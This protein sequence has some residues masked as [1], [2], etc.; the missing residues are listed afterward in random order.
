MT[1]WRSSRPKAPADQIDI[2]VDDDNSVP[3]PP[4]DLPPSEEGV[5]SSGKNDS[6]GHTL[7]DDDDNV[8]EGSIEHPYGAGPPRRKFCTGGRLFCVAVLL[9]LGVAAYLA[10]MTGKGLGGTPGSGSGS[11][12]DVSSAS[13]GGNNNAT[14][15]C[16]DKV[17]VDK[18]CYLYGENIT[19]TF[20]VCDPTKVDWV[21]LHRLPDDA[22]NNTS[23]ED[24][25]ILSD[26]R[27]REWTCG[28]REDEAD[29]CE[30]ATS[31]GTIEVGAYVRPGSFRMYLVSGAEP[32]PTPPYLAVSQTFSS[33]EECP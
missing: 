28:L 10:V 3:P 6:F 11:G 9:L 17:T 23:P 2:S 19:V 1:F 32:S 13:S 4:P 20:A 15:T 22:G 8:E 25:D 30:K 26:Y 27:Y 29:G 14:T 5:Q 24:A 16:T 21:G 33:S 7:I 31:G 12:T 18:G